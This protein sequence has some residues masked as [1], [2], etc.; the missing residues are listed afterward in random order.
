[1]KR[2]NSNPISLKA[3]AEPMPSRQPVE[4]WNGNGPCDPRLRSEPV[5]LNDLDRKRDA[6]D[7]VTPEQQTNPPGG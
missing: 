1:M 6:E 2:E 5:F 7:S 3:S 4:R